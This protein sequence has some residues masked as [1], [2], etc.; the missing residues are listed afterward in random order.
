[1]LKACVFVSDM[2]DKPFSQG[3]DN[4]G[5]SAAE[6]GPG[7]ADTVPTGIIHRSVFP[8]VGKFIATRRVPLSHTWEN[9]TQRAASPG[10]ALWLVPRGVSEA[11]VSLGV[12]VAD[13]AHHLADAGH[14]FL[15]QFAVLHVAAQQVA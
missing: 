3:P 14:L 1:M 7:R 11:E 10:R 4:A 12:P 6:S 8:R 13:I 9:R 5:A 15:G 2:E